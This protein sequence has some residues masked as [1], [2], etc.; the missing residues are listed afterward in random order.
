MTT[1]RELT[2]WVLSWKD[3]D[4]E[5][6]ALFLAC[7]WLRGFDPRDKQNRR[8]AADA[9][10]W[11][12]RHGWPTADGL[13]AWLDALGVEAEVPGPLALRNLRARLDRPRL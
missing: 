8:G 5:M 13:R 1:I 10:G 4:R 7:C 9:W 3:T 11:I 12:A 2:E 6:K